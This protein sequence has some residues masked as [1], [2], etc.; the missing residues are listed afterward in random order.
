MADQLSKDWFE[1][2]NISNIDTPAL[3]VYEERV[4]ENIRLLQN[5]VTDNTKLRPHVKTN[6]MAEVCQLMMDAGITKFKCA[7]IAEAEMLAMLKTK[8]V[9][10]AYQPVGP[11]S[12]R[13]I[14][15][16]K[17]YP[18]TQFACLTDNEQ[19]AGFLNEMAGANQIVLPVFIDLNIGMNRTGIK[20]VDAKAL[21]D[22]ILSLPNLIL[23]GLHAYDGHI[24]DSDITTRKQNVNKAF[25]GVEE[26][27]SYIT[28]KSGKDIAIVA[29]G[30]PTFPVH[31]A[32]KNVECSP[33]TFVFT[34]WGYKHILP[35]EPFDYAALVATRVI[36]IVNEQT[37]CTDLGH[38]SV[39]AENPLP[40]VHF[41]NATAAQPI[42]QSEEHLVL[43][44]DDATKYRVG[45][46]LYAV[47]V[48]ICPTVALYEKAFIVNNTVADKEWKV[49][50]RNRYI[51]F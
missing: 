22:H 43:K 40:R 24:R 12:S 51:N 39:A 35:D 50:A 28:N 44:V 45:D 49:I 2:S 10:L 34:D 26:L 6:K 42:G 17:A 14:N 36:S 4:K 33:G 15:L 41:L 46:V 7:T 38:K 25:A 20:L 19:S 27:Q 23:A 18:A 29:G 3:L 32:R 21:A 30:T 13:L 37:I 47:P 9:L 8:D 16:I 1:V 48:H 11:K 31:A 5:I